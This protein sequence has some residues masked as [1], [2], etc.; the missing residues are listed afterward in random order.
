[1]KNLIFILIVGLLVAG[2]LI[3][4]N[5]RIKIKQ[6]HALQITPYT[7]DYQKAFVTHHRHNIKLPW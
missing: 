2:T 1:M 4:A 7:T 3:P 6:Q 5:A